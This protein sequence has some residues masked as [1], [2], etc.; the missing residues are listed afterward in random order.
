MVLRPRG[1]S[2]ARLAA[3][4]VLR[5]EQGQHM[6]RSRIGPG[7]MSK[8][9][10][11]GTTAQACLL[12]VALCGQVPLRTLA[13]GNDAERGLPLGVAV[14]DDVAVCGPSFIV[15]SGVRLH[16]APEAGARSRSR[17]S[18]SAQGIPV[19]QSG[20]LLLKEIFLK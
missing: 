4:G 19:S 15:G 14:P 17:D 18:S 9:R 20:D 8:A 1:P 16:L 10:D 2:H 11:P 6:A 5:E 3:A 13:G 7:P 12:P